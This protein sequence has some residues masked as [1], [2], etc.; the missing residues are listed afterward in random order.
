MARFFHLAAAI[1]LKW[2]LLG[3][4]NLAAYDYLTKLGPLP[5]ILNQS[6][7]DRWTE[8]SSLSPPSHAD[9]F[10]LYL[11]H[12]PKTGGTSLASVFHALDEARDI[13]TQR[14]L[15]KV[16][17]CDRNNTKIVFFHA[18]FQ[19]DTVRYWFAPIVVKVL[20]ISFVRDPLERVVSH[21]NFACMPLEESRYLKAQKALIGN[22]QTRFLGGYDW[23]GD[24]NECK[25]QLPTALANMNF[26]FA[27]I[28]ET[29]RFTESVWL[30]QHMFGWGEDIVRRSLEYPSRHFSGCKDPPPKWTVSDVDNKTKAEVVRIEAC[31]GIVHSFGSALLEARL[32]LL[33]PDETQ[34]LNA[35]M[36]EFPV[37]S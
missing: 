36:A 10:V 1:V 26:V 29:S 20:P 37:D 33:T 18:Q 28:G 17:Q 4:A 23:N 2:S 3:S 31:D 32:A 35:L 14:G 34:Q 7:R 15:G 19:P 9:N 11:V 12:T 24:E 22:Y 30:L 5:A 27:F 8:I 21:A 6:E 16:S 13:C 25:K